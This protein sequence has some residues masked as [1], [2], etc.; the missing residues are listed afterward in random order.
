MRRKTFAKDSKLRTLNLGG[1]A[2]AM[3][4][5]LVAAYPQSRNVVVEIDGALATTSA[6]GL[7]CPGRRC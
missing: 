5:Y 2:C 4:R 1:A 7:T 6:T 3:P